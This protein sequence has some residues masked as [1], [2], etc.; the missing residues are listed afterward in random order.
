MLVSPGQLVV[1]GISIAVGFVVLALFGFL[2]HATIVIILVL[3]W[4]LCRIAR[5]AWVTRTDRRFGIKGL[6]PGIGSDDV[7][8][9]WG[10]ERPAPLPDTYQSMSDEEQKEF[11]RN[12]GYR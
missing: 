5:E 12:R 2:L 7:I 6:P 8:P 11:L 10:C 3:T 4:P 9:D 1:I